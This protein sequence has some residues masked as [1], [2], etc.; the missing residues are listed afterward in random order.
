MNLKIFILSCFFGCSAIAAIPKAALILQKTVENDGN[1]VYQIEQEVQFPNGSDIL[2]LKETWLI[3]NESNMKLIVT[4]TK[5]LKDQFF[6]SVN[7][8]GGTRNQAGNTKRLGEDFIE[9]YFHYRKT[10]NFAYAL[11]QLKI[12]P[13]YVLSRKNLRSLKDVDNS[14][15][16]FVHLS[17]TGGVVTYMLGQESTE[18]SALPAFW[19][20]QDQFVL[21]KF[22]LPSQVEV[23][24]DRYSNYSR[25]LNFPRT[26]TVRWENNQVTIQTISVVGKSKD[27]FSKFST[28]GAQK[29]DALKT[30]AAA[31]IVEEFYKRFR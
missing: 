13:T 19:I 17:R 1:G 24:A 7:Y 15:E 12:V 14:V 23:S 22:R 27:T 26:R 31:D 5:E 25:G 16:P 28:G 30:Q 8:S 20:E 6:I 21:R 2:I 11:S 4:G 3:Q 29:T 9:K 18:T 10:E